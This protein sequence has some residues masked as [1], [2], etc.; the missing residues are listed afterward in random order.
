MLRVPEN[1]V[2]AAVERLSERMRELS[3]REREGDRE[4]TREVADGLVGAATEIG[5]LGLVAAVVEVP[6]P[7]SLL[8][9]SDRVKQTLGNAAVVLGS[10]VDGRAHLVANF[11]DA[12]VERGLK[13]GEVVRAAAGLVGGGGGG[14]D[15]MAQA[16][17]RDPERLP[18]AIAAARAAIEVELA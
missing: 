3:A 17:G 10:A 5:G 1:D 11:S 7:R 18:E 13:A 14:R 2:V 12:A 16:G 15:G 6:D 9:L 4:S 8:E